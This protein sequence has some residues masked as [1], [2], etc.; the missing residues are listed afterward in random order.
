MYPLHLH[1]IWSILDRLLHSIF[2]VNILYKYLLFLTF[3]LFIMNGCTV[4]QKIQKV[5]F[6]G[7]DP[8]NRKDPFS[9]EL[10]NGDIIP[11]RFHDVLMMEVND[12]LFIVYYKTGENIN[13]RINEIEAIRYDIIDQESKNIKT[14]N[15]IG[16]TAGVLV[17][18]AIAVVSIALLYSF[19]GS[20]GY[21]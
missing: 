8:A 12:S 9:V 18:I 14:A 6:S 11:V 10:K 17:S 2:M 15:T 19:F 7:Y 5:P 3:L 21:L 1:Y 13:F 4:Q 20:R 16:I